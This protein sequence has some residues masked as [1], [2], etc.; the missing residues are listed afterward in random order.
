MAHL[1]SFTEGGSAA[2]S[3]L[4]IL[5]IVS[6]ES[7]YDLYFTDGVMTESDS[8]CDLGFECDSQDG[9]AEDSRAHTCDDTRTQTHTHTHTHTFAR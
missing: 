5:D 9:V 6:D 4:L 3:A 7:D 1:P 2:G 8:A